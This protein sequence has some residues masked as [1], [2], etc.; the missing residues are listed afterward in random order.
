MFNAYS[1]LYVEH[2]PLSREV[3]Q[4]LMGNAMGIERLIVWDDSQNFEKSLERLST[5][6]DLILLDIH[7]QPNDGFDMLRM[8]RKDKNFS[9]AKVIALTASVMQEEVSKLQSSGFDGVIGKPVSIKT[10][11]ALIERVLKGETIW[12]ILD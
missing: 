8:I 9:G 3:L 10:F 1:Y 6:P 7:M 4:M 12:H 2:D 5:C 11:P